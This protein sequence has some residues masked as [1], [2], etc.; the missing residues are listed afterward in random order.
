MGAGFK[1]VHELL[2]AVV[3][4]A[5]DHADVIAERMRAL[6]ALA[7]GRSNA[8]VATTLLPLMEV[9]GMDARVVANTIAGRIATTVDTMRAVRDAVDAEDPPTA[10]LL[11]GVIGDLERHAWMLGASAR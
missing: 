5:R 2:D 9:G 10:E 6:H 1:A 4:T 3:D 7:D 11:N 8:I